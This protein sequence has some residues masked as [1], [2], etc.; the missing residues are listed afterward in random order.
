MTVI[1]A[2]LLTP[3]YVAEIVTA[4]FFLVA[5]VVTVKLFEIVPPATTTLAGTEAVPGFELARVTTAP[6]AG[7]GA[8]SVTVPVAE[9]PPTTAAGLSVRLATAA[10]GAGLTVN[11][12][13]LVTPLYDAESVVRVCV[14]TLEVVMSNVAELAL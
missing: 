12:A 2:V 13:V 4:V 6:P 1:V 5:A 11:V 14:A 7:A 10:D 3:E 8:V 9:V